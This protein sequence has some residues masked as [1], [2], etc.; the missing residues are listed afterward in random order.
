MEL[1]PEAY[2]VAS[3][4]NGRFVF[5]R[6]LPVNLHLVRISITRHPDVVTIGRMQRY[7]VEPRPGQTL[8]LE[9][10]KDT[11]TVRLRVRL[12]EELSLDASRQLPGLS[13]ES[14]RPGRP[15][16]QVRQQPEAMGAWY[17]RPEV[18]AALYERRGWPLRLTADGVWEAHE[19]QPRHWMVRT[20]IQMEAPGPAADTWEYFEAPVTVPAD[21][22]GEVVDLGEVLLQPAD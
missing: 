5:D 13:L 15:P 11:R 7:Q 17:W 21:A 20:A 19:V 18:R 12:P 8:R 4:R 14:P 3:D 6:V 2:R 1:D 9:V 16:R 22:E 10:G